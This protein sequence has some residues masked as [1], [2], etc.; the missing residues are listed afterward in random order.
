MRNK[1][2]W[3]K[4]R[5]GIMRVCFWDKGQNFLSSEGREGDDAWWSDWSGS[6]AA[7]DPGSDLV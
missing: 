2:N 1:E 7:S 6:G 5:G 3:E 4:G